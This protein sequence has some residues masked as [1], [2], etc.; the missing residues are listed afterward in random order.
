MWRDWLRHGLIGLGFVAKPDLA[1]EHMIDH[2]SPDDLKPG[3]LIVVKDG[4]LAKWACF[5][6]PGGCGERIQLSLGLARRPRWSVALDWL[7]RPT[8]EPSVRQLNACRC[9]FWVR[10]G[11]VEWCADSGQDRDPR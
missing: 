8:L 5:R 6:C 4:A 1:A 7:R 10:H 3:R 2:P 11:K 9:H